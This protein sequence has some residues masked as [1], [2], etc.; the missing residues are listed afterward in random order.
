MTLHNARYDAK[1]DT[2][3]IRC[4]CQ[5]VPW[6]GHL[7]RKWAGVVHEGPIQQR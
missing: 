1:T 3:W 6:P 7:A 2:Y 4:G 5:S